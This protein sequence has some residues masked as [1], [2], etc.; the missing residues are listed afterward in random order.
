MSSDRKL[1]I[2]ADDFGLAPE[3]NRGVRDAYREGVLTATTL[4]PNGPAFEDAVRIAREEDMPVGI[5][6]G[7]VQEKP[8]SPV[9]EISSLVDEEGRLPAD[10]RTFIR[11][12]L[13][14]QIDREQLREEIRRQIETVL[15]E[16]LRVSH[17]D[18]HQHLHVFP[19]VSSIVIDL[20]REYDIPAVRVPEEWTGNRWISPVSVT[21]LKRLASHFRT[22]LQEAKIPHNRLF[23]GVLQTDTPAASMMENFL[24]DL[25]TG[26]TELALHLSASEFRDGRRFQKDRDLIGTYDWVVSGEVRS[27]FNSSDVQLVGWRSFEEAIY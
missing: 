6:L 19:G 22:R 24:A 4:L 11:Q 10:Y 12:Y 17:L 14:G 21:V 2:T 7:L 13:L 16:D 8:V 18:S 9:Q 15:N 3:I 27:L 5:H 25:P 1:I 20:V 23:R 26:V